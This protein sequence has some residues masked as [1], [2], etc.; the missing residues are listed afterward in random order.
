LELAA[1]WA[2]AG[3]APP[4]IDAVALARLCQRAENEYVGVACGLMDQFASSV[5]G[6][7]GALVL[8]C[9]SL[10]HRSVRLPPDCLLVVCHT[11]SERRLDASAYNQR[12]MECQRAVS[13]IAR[14]YPRVRS[15]RDVDGAMLA[16]VGGELDAVALR[17]AEHV[18]TENQRV[19]ATETALG[20][21]DLSAV[22]RL[23]AESHASLRELYEVSS[24]ELDALVDIATATPGV[25]AARLTGAGFGGCT[26]NLV[27]R[28][29]VARLRA[30]IAHEYPRRT[31]RNPRIWEVEPVAG[32]GVVPG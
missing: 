13:L 31:G 8:D 26:V 28:T 1:A 18:V 25:V 21:G 15:L 22:G 23:W 4:E 24:A 7:A 29:A 11:G 30:A 5:G 14:R 32:A 9:R 27:R 12:R 10:E 20:A 17:R 6:A 16:S 3:E 19:L 2:L